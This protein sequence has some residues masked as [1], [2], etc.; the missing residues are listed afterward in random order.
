MV[1]EIRKLVF[2]PD[3][4]VTAIRAYC[5]RKGI[6][7]PPSKPTS[8]SLG[9]EAESVVRF[10]FS[11]AAGEAEFVFSYHEAAAAVNRERASRREA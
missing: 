9:V 10:F 11:E 7:L 1:V 3:E 6:K 5:A 8:L 2:D 4:I